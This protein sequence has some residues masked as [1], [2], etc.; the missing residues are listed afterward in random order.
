MQGRELLVTYKETE[1]FLCNVSLLDHRL[2]QTYVHLSHIRIWKLFFKVP[3]C[4]FPKANVFSSIP[5]IS[6]SQILFY[7]F[8]IPGIIL[9]HI[10]WI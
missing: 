2:F 5:L 6:S 7:K 3:R 10:A 1:D 9:K 8:A 4:D